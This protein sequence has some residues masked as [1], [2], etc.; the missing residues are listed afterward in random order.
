MDQ[1]FKRLKGKLKYTIND[2]QHRHLFV[3]SLFPHLKYPLRQHKFQSK[4]EAL[5]ETLQLEENQYKHIDLAVEEMK[6]FMK[7][8]TFQLNQNK[9]RK[10]VK[11]SS[12]Q[13]A[14]QKAITRMSVHYLCSIL[15]WLCQTLYL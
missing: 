8:L 2:T 6:Q 4:G 9:E 15:E 12:L 5:Q 1:K 13:C 14:T 11:M 10:K 7:N 3:N